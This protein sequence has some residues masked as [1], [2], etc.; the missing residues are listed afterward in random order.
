MTMDLSWDVT[1]PVGAPVLV[2]LNSL[3]SDKSMW[4][5][6]FNSLTEQF[7]VVRVDHRGHGNSP[8]APPGQ[9]AT[10][11]DLGA[12]VVRVLDTVCANEGFGSV[13]IAGLSLG[14][15]VAMWIAAHH[16]N[17]VNRLALL[18][19]SAFMPPA[20]AWLD[21]AVAVRADGMAR[22]AS[23]VTQRWITPALAERDPILLAR[24]TAMVSA[25]DPESYAQCC[26]AI[27]AMDLRS[28]LARIAAPTLVISGADDPAAPPEQGEVIAAGI[29]R[30]QFSVVGPAAHVAV[31]EQTG[32]VTSLLLDHFRGGATLASGFRTRR[33]VLGDEQVD[34]AIATSTPSTAAFQQFITRYAWGDVWTRPELTRRERSIA[35]LSALVT[36]GAE[37]EIPMHV[38]AALRNGLLPEQI[39]EVLL[40]TA[41]YA[42]LPR[43]NRAFALARD[44]LD[45]ATSPPVA[46]T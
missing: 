30:S 35:T 15:M 16:P 32:L 4:D 12:D 36:L 13:D 41:V 27:A 46:N 42:G 44:I 45:D 5:G 40:H 28:D 20:Q 43:A 33:Q 10:I 39:S 25:A 2:L 8:T 14:A 17:K 3:G 31:V 7:R 11:A 21:R 38:R 24:L 23:A 1:G 9:P 19:T 22:V 18:C 26:E 37:H 6:A 34:H 29:H